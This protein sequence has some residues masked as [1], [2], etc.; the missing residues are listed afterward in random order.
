M[1]LKINKQIIMRF[2]L[3]FMLCC[4]TISMITAE[5]TM[6][7]VKKETGIVLSLT[8]ASVVS[9]IDAT[10]KPDKPE[11][12]M[13]KKITFVPLNSYSNGTVCKYI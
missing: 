8:D 6:S 4:V 7:Q 13:D 3:I 10:P 11:P 12:K 2:T 9:V 1:Y 5:E